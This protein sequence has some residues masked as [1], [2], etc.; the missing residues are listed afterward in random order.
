MGVELNLMRHKG[1]RLFI[2]NDLSIMLEVK[3]SGLVE[4]VTHCYVDC[5]WFL[6]APVVKSLNFYNN[7]KIVH[8]LKAT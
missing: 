7:D 3:E 8:T 1:I 2:E 6:A 5:M 4:Q